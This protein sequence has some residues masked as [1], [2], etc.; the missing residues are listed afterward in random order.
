MVVFWNTLF[1]LLA[2]LLVASQSS[3]PTPTISGVVLLSS[4]A[5]LDPCMETCFEEAAGAN[6]CAIDDVHCTCASAQL[7]EDL[8]Q[9]LDAECSAFSAPQAQGLLFQLCSKAQVSATG[10]ATPGHLSLSSA[11]PTAPPTGLP[12]IQNHKSGARALRMC[13]G[14]FV[15]VVATTTALWA[16]VLF[17]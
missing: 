11:T 10:S 6:S 9:C 1:F 4:T 2:A 5:G 7:Q 17:D 3:T 12:S 16:L 14:T 15:G 13:P 8:T